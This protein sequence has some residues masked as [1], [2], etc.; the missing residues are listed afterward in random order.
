MPL[1]ICK[2]R[3][4]VG[5]TL[6]QR[7][8]DRTVDLAEL[9]INVCQGCVLFGNTAIDVGNANGDRCLAGNR[10]GSFVRGS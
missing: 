9:A 2:R 7:L 1:V 3:R 5:A 4:G 10:G 8:V 6:L